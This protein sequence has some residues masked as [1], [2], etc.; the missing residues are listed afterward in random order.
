[1]NAYCIAARPLGWS[2]MATPSRA[3]LVVADG[4]EAALAAGRERFPSDWVYAEPGEQDRHRS[5]RGPETPSKM[6]LSVWEVD[7]STRIDP[8]G[9]LADFAE[10]YAAVRASRP[11]PYLDRDHYD[12][13]RDDQQT[14]RIEGGGL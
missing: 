3:T 8:H 1:M 6:W 7:W 14:E 4:P 13:W 2:S 11:D 9:T 5:G 10:A 12:R